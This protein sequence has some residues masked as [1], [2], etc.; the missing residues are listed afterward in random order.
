VHADIG[1]AAGKGYTIGDQ[2]AVYENLAIGF[3][4]VKLDTRPSQK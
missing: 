1:I 4:G 2:T 3:G